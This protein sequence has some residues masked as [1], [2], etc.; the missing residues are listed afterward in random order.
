MLKSIFADI[1]KWFSSLTK[2]KI[3]LTVIV[4][5]LII[6]PVFIALGNM[7]HTKNLPSQ[8]L[9]KITLYD[10]NGKEIAYESVAPETADEESLTRI[11]Y[12]LSSSQQRPTELPSYIDTSR[13]VRAVTVHNGA[14]SE[15]ICY[16]SPEYRSGYYIDQ[17]KTVYPISQELCDIFLASQYSELFYDTSRI[18][19]LTSADHDSIIPTSITWMYKAVTGEYITATRNE[20][21]PKEKIYEITGSIDISFE[22]EPDSYSITVYDQGDK[23]YSGKNLDLSSVTA[24]SGDE[25]RVVIYA[26][27]YM[28][29]SEEC[30]GEASYDFYVHI[31]NRS[32][33]TVNTDKVSAGELI[34][35]ECTNI[36]NIE[37]ILFTSNI[38]EL[39]PVFKRNGDKVIAL[40]PCAHY[41]KE[42][43]INFTIAYGAS[44]DEFN[45]EVVP[46][47]NANEYLYKKLLFD[48]ESAPIARNDKIE[49]Q[50]KELSLSNDEFVY[51]RG[52]FISPTE[53]GFK[54]AASHNDTIRWGE[55]LE[56]TFSAL[57]NRYTVDTSTPNGELVKVIESGRVAYI[58]SNELL[59]QFVVIEH[60]CGLR[61]WYT[62][63]SSVDVSVGDILLKNESIGKIGYDSIYEEYG[64]TLYCT[65]FDETVDPVSLFKKQ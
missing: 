31:K 64:F 12:E 11:F 14:S 18:Y 41:I 8:H 65:V 19:S 2:K 57:G 15:L 20:I 4:C 9:F 60:G 13:F 22:K 48:T 54:I 61:T 53:N 45:I 52:N 29:D 3:I 32:E 10:N 44:M 55:N 47:Q 26:T 49:Q 38:S 63:L 5:M 7:I 33:F 46:Y 40:V 16:F 50:M 34:I 42:K 35:I 17:S 39:S 24:K 27:W 62:N 56:Y 30:H 43:S 1:R 6:S 28:D 59:G 25:L 23:I 37:K 51:F 58:G 36:T 21:T